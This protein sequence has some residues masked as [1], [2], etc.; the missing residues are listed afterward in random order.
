MHFLLLGIVSCLVA[1]CAVTCLA[2][3]QVKS[4]AGK[5]AFMFMT[6]GVMPLEEV[7]HEFFTDPRA[8]PSEYSIYLHPTMRGRHKQR[9]SVGPGSFFAGKE[10]DN[11]VEVHYGGWTFTQAMLNLLET[12]LQD[13]DNQFFCM[14]TDS[15]IPLL[16]FPQWR[17]V[18]LHNGKSVINSC[19][20]SIAEGSERDT[21]WSPKMDNLFKHEHWRKSSSWSALTRKHAELVVKPYAFTDAFKHARISDEH[22]IPSVIAY[23]GLDKET[24]CNDG[25]MY[26]YWES[27]AAAHPSFHTSDMID[28]ELFF[29]KFKGM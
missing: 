7:W 2:E 14:L 26:V 27:L 9:G 20:M 23:H 22:Y 4:P 19:P 12:A 28:E 21:R 15:C 5:I 11:V 17:R 3:E 1:T 18:L 29:K 13:K 16:P 25:Y 24:T 8:S 6:R 10:I